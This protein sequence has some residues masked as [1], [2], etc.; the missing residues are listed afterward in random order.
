MTPARTFATGTTTAGVQAETMNEAS[1]AGR[2]DQPAAVAPVFQGR[3]LSITSYKR[4][5][6][7]VATPVW[8]V[9]RDGRLL[10][11]TD[12]ASG[13]VKRIRRNPQVRVAVCNAGGRLRGEQVPAVAQILPGSEIG[14]VERLI[15]DKYRFDMIIFRPLRFV[16]ARLHLGR[17]RTGPAI[18]GITPS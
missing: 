4:D 6:Q 13:K 15:A 8:F 11:E 3:Y 17:S 9:Q 5:G 10:V 7:G 14:A 1:S 18:L 2:P 16:Q 12:A